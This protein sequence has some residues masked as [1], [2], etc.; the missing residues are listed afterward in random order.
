MKRMF[1]LCVA[2]VLIVGCFVGCAAEVK[3]KKPSSG[4]QNTTSVSSVETHNARFKILDT[5]G[6]TV[7]TENHIYEANVGDG[8]VNG[9]YYVHLKLDRTG[10][11]LLKYVTSQSIGKKLP[12]YL[13]GE[14]IFEPKVNLAI[15][16]GEFHITVDTREEA[17]KIYNGISAAMHG[18]GK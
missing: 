7:I 5:K 13:D 11:E 14:L 4:E 10:T 17:E 18:E 6:N 2:L 8:T 1:A 15:E 3:N 12:F 9:K 16:D